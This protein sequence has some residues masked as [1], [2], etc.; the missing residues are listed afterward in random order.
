MASAPMTVRLRIERSTSSSMMPFMLLHCCGRLILSVLG[1]RTLGITLCPCGFP[2]EGSG[3]GSV[4]PS[5]RV[6]KAERRRHPQQCKSIKGFI[7]SSSQGS[8]HI[9]HS[10]VEQEPRAQ[11][12]SSV[13][14]FR[15]K[16]GSWQGLIGCRGFLV[17]TD[18]PVII[19]LIGQRYHL[20]DWPELPSL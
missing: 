4:M 7:A 12:Y 10:G 18:W 8:C 2:G 1:T 5:V 20:S 15:T 13:Y 9:Q 19:P 14:K 17:F 16:T 6:P 11:I 3:V